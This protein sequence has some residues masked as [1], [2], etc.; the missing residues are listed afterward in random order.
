MRNTLTRTLYRTLGV[1]LT[2]YCL[3]S[4][5]SRSQAALTISSATIDTTGKIVTVN[6][7]GIGTGPLVPAA[8]LNG[9]TVE[10]PGGVV[11]PVNN[12]TAG[13]TTATINLLATIPTGTTVTLVY[14]APG[15]NLA[16]SAAA[17][18]KLLSVTTAVTNSSTVSASAFTDTLNSAGGTGELSTHVPTVGTAANTQGWTWTNLGTSTLTLSGGRLSQIPANYQLPTSYQAN[19]TACGPN[20]LF[21]ADIY[22]ASGPG[23]QPLTFNVL[24]SGSGATAAYYGF[25]LRPNHVSDLNNFLSVGKISPVAGSGGIT[26]GLVISSMAA[27]VVGSTY[28]V[29]ME[30]Y[31]QNVHDIRNTLNALTSSPGTD[32]ASGPAQ[33]VINIYYGPQGAPTLIGTYFDRSVIISGTSPS[34]VFAS[35]MVTTPG[36][37]TIGSLTQANQNYYAVGNFS[38]AYSSPKASTVVA[39]VASYVSA[40]D[41][42]GGA[43]SAV[44]SATQAIPSALDGVP[45]YTVALYRSSLINDPTNSGTS[46][47][48]ATLPSTAASDTATDAL[49]SYGVNSYYRYRATDTLGATSDSSQVL[50]RRDTPLY[51]GCI[52]DSIHTGGGWFPLFQEIVGQ[53]GNGRRSVNDQIDQN[54]AGLPANVSIYNA[55]VSGQTTG[56]YIPGTSLYNHIKLVWNNLADASPPFGLVGTACGAGKQPTVVGITLGANNAHDVSTT[57]A[58]T[59]TTPATY[60][61]Q[62]VAICTGL[63]TDVPSVKTII[64]H[65]PIYSTPGAYGGIW[66][67]DSPEREVQYA[68]T[69]AAVAASVNSGRGT[70]AVFVG[71][72]SGFSFFQNNPTLLGTPPSDGAHPQSG[73]GTS[74]M[75]T[76]EATAVAR[77][78][79]PT[80]A[81]SSGMKRRTQ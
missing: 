4:I 49:A 42:T 47:L 10:S 34:R 31:R 66:S 33:T 74:Y 75:A 46:T 16:D 23:D 8:G 18:S 27:P 20:A 52:G 3:L 70:P 55:A 1:L 63:L 53:A 36:Q 71:D 28:T 80:V 32:T 48:V 5:T 58:Y 77:I 57:Q 51:Y 40:S 38:L 6:V 12:E 9:F 41:G 25:T 50:Q 21:S 64:I 19:T 24:T 62:L 79:Y 78:L 67:L 13:T 72:T 29:R 44:Y 65:A 15:G 11:W 56:S 39:P 2:A 69:L 73:L 81:P 35:N 59:L 26:G 17:P 68:T 76:M 37:F 30:I 14:D 7:S 54:G 61:S 60:Q 22:V 43:T 45:P